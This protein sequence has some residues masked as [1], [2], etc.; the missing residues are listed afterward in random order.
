[1][2]KN[3]N[4]RGNVSCVCLNCGTITKTD[5]HRA[6]MGYGKYCSVPCRMEHAGYK[7]QIL[8]VL[9]ATMKQI[10]E[11]SR[12]EIGTVRKQI[13]LLQRT[14]KCHASGITPFTGVM[15]KGHVAHDIIYSP[16][17]AADPAVPHEKQRAISY[18]YEKM[19]LAA[20]PG[21]QLKLSETTGLAQSTVSRR[22]HSMHKD[23]KCH[24]HRWRKSSSGRRMAVYKA[25]A[26]VD[27]VCAI[28][29]LTQKEINARFRAR[30]VRTGRVVEIRER[31]NAS[32]RAARMRKDGDPLVTALFGKPAERLKEAA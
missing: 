26:G 14:G 5:S 18:F 23:G 8:A 25:G 2:T 20:M 27:A 31:N 9:P 16:G 7:R 4:R 22:V 21:T 12:V 30:L 17:P 10:V 1:M 19:I 11:R 6:S 13:L 24:I 32:A 29:P 28:A 3:I 15:G